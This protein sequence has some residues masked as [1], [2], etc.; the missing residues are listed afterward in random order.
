MSPQSNRV[1]ESQV[2]GTVTQEIKRTLRLNKGMKLNSYFCNCSYQ[3]VKL[4]DSESHQPWH[5]LL[6]MTD[7]IANEL[8]HKN[9][10]HSS[11][12]QTVFLI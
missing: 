9:P 3:N 11:S 4:L 7:E 8:L 2:L 10:L 1:S 6:L 12:T 5:T